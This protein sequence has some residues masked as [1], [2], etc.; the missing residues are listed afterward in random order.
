MGHS[1]R[2]RRSAA[3]ARIRH[4]GLAATLPLLTALLLAPCAAAHPAPELSGIWIL[5]PTP[6]GSRYALFTSADRSTLTANWT[7][8]PGPH[9]GLVGSF[10]GTRNAAGTSYTGP[11][12]VSEGSTVVDGTMTWTVDVLHLHFLFPTLDVTY[13][14][15]NG[16]GG[17]FHLQILLLPGRVDPAAIDTVQEHVDCPDPTPCGWR[18]AAES[19][20]NP[21]GPF[22]PAATSAA[23]QVFG[24]A[25]FTV[26]PHK[27]ATL[28]VH[29]NKAARNLLAQR[30]SLK[31]K[32]VLTLTKGTGLPHT[33]SGG[34][35]TFHKT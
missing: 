28:R 7:G 6:D 8:A 20:G 5:S 2:S 14:Q 12:H 1:T 35:V 21:F 34:V 25:L 31:V 32:V 3:G 33:M 18:M 17:S 23:A 15:S 26:Q 10:Q 24:S 11:L 22:R 29:L 9:A 30:G 27:S 19:S 13:Q 16:V 4:L